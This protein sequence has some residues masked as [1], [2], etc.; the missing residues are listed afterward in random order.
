MAWRITDRFNPG[1][2]RF[3]NDASNG[4]DLPRSSDVLASVRTKGRALYQVLFRAEP[5]NI[6]LS[7]LCWVCPEREG[8]V[9]VAGQSAAL[10]LFVSH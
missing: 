9:I 8:V 5:Q 10:G 7:A 4:G 1:L 3:E 2:H 6:L